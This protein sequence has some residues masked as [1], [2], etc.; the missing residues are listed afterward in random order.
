MRT[1]LLGVLLLAS[2]ADAKDLT[3]RVNGHAVHLDVMP[4]QSTQP[5]P[6]VVFESGPR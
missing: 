1:L 3:V 4:P 5:G 2:P 6:A